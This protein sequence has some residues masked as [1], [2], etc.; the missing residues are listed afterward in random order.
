M[1]LSGVLFDQSKHGVDKYLPGLN[2]KFQS[3]QRIFGFIV[4]FGCFVPGSLAFV[5]SSYLIPLFHSAFFEEIS[6]CIHFSMWLGHY[7]SLFFAVGHDRKLNG[8]FPESSFLAIGSYNWSNSW[9]WTGMSQNFFRLL[10][11]IKVIQIDPHDLLPSLSVLIGLLSFLESPLWLLRFTIFHENYFWFHLFHNR[12]CLFEH[13]KLQVQNCS[14]LEILCFFI[15]LGC[16]KELFHILADNSYIQQQ[17]FI[18]DLPRYV[19]PSL[20]I[21]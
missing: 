15:D 10:K 2:I 14:L 1:L 6:I 21:S 9:S 16:F 19:E 11:V 13:F 7:K 12:S 20:D 17:R 5:I 18:F 3:F 8:L 4:L